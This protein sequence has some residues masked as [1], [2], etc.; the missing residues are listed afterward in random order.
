[1]VGPLLTQDR[2][3][4][5]IACAVGACELIP[6]RHE[7]W[8]ALAAA[9]D[10]P[11]MEAHQ[12]AAALKAISIN[13]A[14][15]IA[16]HNLS[17]A[18]MRLYRWPDALVAAHTAHTH[19]WCNPYFILQGATIASI[20][21]DYEG[22]ISL[23]SSAIHVFQQLRSQLGEEEYRQAMYQMH[24][25]RRVVEVESQSRT[26]FAT[27]QVRVP[28]EH[29]LPGSFLRRA[30]DSDRLWDPV[31]DVNASVMVFL[32]DGL[33]DQMQFAR[34]LPVFRKANP[35][36][37]HMTV[38]CSKVLLSWIITMPCVDAV[39]CR[40]TDAAAQEMVLASPHISIVGSS[41]LPGWNYR[42]NGSK[43]PFGAWEGPYLTA[44]G[45][46]EWRSTHT[47]LGKTAIAFVWRGNPKFAY[48]WMRQFPLEMFLKW[49]E[50]RRDTCTF[51]SFQM[52]AHENSVAFPDW[53]ED[54]MPGDGA[55]MLETARRL[56][57]MNAL[58]TR[59]TAMVH[60]AG[61]INFPTV[62]LHPYRVDWR[63]TLGYPLYNP[64]T[65]AHLYQPTPGDWAGA[66]AQLGPALDGL[67]NTIEQYELMG[68][69]ACR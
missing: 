39:V 15:P 55:D 69:L 35:Q 65:M 22:S 38:C 24:V 20:M 49:A 58:V 63:Y 8:T 26:T 32:E 9:Y 5:A 6:H 18:L 43:T 27:G 54:C 7:V 41:D 17:L 44:Y 67:L 50:L 47:T 2:R 23:F 61:A 31:D 12:E 10:F 56:K 1:M 30:F 3:D 21:G 60:L 13:S 46:T 52:G 51:H 29:G 42:C 4:E 11:G 59:D 25:A 34:L 53:V 37:Q 45:P 16:W 68:A 57:H 40:E 28:R 19:D 62:L 66:F 33:G 36:I 14:D 64:A 48:E